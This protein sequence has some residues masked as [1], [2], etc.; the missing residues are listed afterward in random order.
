MILTHLPER[1]IAAHTYAYRDRPLDVAVESIAELGF[2]AVE[3]WVGHATAG[4]LHVA[5]VLA[6]T[7]MRAVA[8]S[9]GGFYDENTS[10][11]ARSF[12]LARAVGAETVVACVSPRA[13]PQLSRSVPEGLTLCIENHWDQFARRPGDVRRLLARRAPATRLAACLDTGHA[14]VAG[15][16]PQRFAAGLGSSLAH[17]HL[18]DASR[19]S[20]IEVA[21][22]PRLRRRL[23]PRPQPV[24]AGTGDLDVARLLVAL[25]RLNYR[26]WITVEDEGADVA[27]ALTA[28]RV[29][30]LTAPAPNAAEV[31]S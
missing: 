18:K 23:R 13:L 1:R 17:I 28:L 12:D 30:L 2:S 11:A 21:L 15:V 4:P 27:S 24:A 7:G 19:P 6:A 22:G 25:D 10:S 9:A 14:I 16:D 8:V 20:P 3:V 29:A 5:N 26:G 31:H